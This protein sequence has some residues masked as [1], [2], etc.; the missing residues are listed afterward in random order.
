MNNDFNE[1]EVLTLFFCDIYGTIDGGLTEEE[2]VVF[3]EL[4]EKIRVK[5]NSDYLYFGMSST[6]HPDV[7]DM[8]ESRLSRYFKDRI[9]LIPKDVE[10][11]VLREIKISYTLHHINKLLKTFNINEIYFAD[12]SQFNHDIFEVLLGEYKIKLNSIVPKRDENYLSFINNEYVVFCAARISVKSYSASSILTV[13]FPLFRAVL[14][15]TPSASSL[16]M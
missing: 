10:S 15:T 12:D 14:L 13:K 11:E 6:E 1:K 3:A 4:L 7:V 8:Y 9:V 5:N 2:C 16:D